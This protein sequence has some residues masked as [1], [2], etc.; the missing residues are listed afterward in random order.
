MY[1]FMNKT[2]RKEYKQLIDTISNS[3]FCIE[4]IS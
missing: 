4:V 3:N 1:I 2:H